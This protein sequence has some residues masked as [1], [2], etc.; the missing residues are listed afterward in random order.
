MRLTN[1]N[2]QIFISAG[3]IIIIILSSFFFSCEPG[4]EYF[5]KIVIENSTSK[6][7][8]AFYLAEDDGTTESSEIQWGEN[9]LST[10]VGPGESYSLERLDQ[11]FYL[12]KTV[13]AD[14]SERIDECNLTLFSTTLRL[15]FTD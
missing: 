9:I 6:E 1:K 4:D 12:L 10:S 2:R 7:I 3:L 8:T 11:S 5:A 13:F 14:G 15:R